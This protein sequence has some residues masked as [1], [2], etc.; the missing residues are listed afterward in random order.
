MQS[1]SLAPAGRA[2][3]LVLLGAILLAVASA[4]PY[5]G[6]WNDGSR[7]AAVESIADRGTLAID[8]SLFVRVPADT[9]ARGIPPYPRHQRDLLAHGTRDRLFIRGHFYSDKPYV[10]SFLMAGIYK[11][12]R[13]F[14]L[15][16]AAERPDL[17]CRV[18]TILTSGL[19]YVVA[20]WCVSLLTVRVGLPPPV[21]LALTA[22]FALSTVALP[23]TRHVNNHILHLG[24]TMALLL[25]LVG[26]ADEAISGSNSWR[27]PLL[28]GML[29]GLAYNLDLGAGPVLLACLFPLI[30]YR[31]RRLGPVLLFLA[32]LAPWL[33]AHHAINYAVGGVLKPMNAVAEYSDWPGSP[34]SKD[35]LTGFFRH[36]PR[37]FVVY[38]L[39]L[40]F[41]KHGFITHNLPLFLAMP[42][43]VF[44]LRRR[45]PA[46]PEIAF[47]AAWCA[48][49]WLMYATFSNNSGGVCC[50]IRWFVPLLAPAYHALTLYLQ[51]RPQQRLDFCILSLWGGLLGL[52][53]WWHG[54][55]I[56]HGVPLLWPL[57]GAGLLSWLACRHAR[58]KEQ[59]SVDD[60]YEMTR[61]A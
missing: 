10:V 1:A 52:A 39:S 11:V 20:V 18:L 34:F 51:Q 44:L 27:R 42:A 28:L 45:S 38:A 31:C 48:G 21:R 22:S 2:H 53:M 16:P 49:T 35:N 3:R 37:T 17:F 50:S 8:D 54:P 61:A 24:V 23:Y 19:A 30:V 9:I 26:L 32:A 56:R 33:L 12:C 55:W 25:Q 29:A 4:L 59:R 41:G 60:H 43:F 36:T 5:A 15:P 57:V 7:L 58:L 47:G 6:S 14:G 13:L 46:R 40:L